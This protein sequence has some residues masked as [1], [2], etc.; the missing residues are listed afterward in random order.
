MKNLFFLLALIAALPASAQRDVV[1]LR[2]RSNVPLYDC[3]IFSDRRDREACVDLRRGRTISYESGGYAVDC[4][5]YRGRPQRTCLRLAENITFNDYAFDCYS[6]PYVQRRRCENTKEGYARGLLTVRQPQAPIEATTTVITTSSGSEVPSTCGPGSYD[7]AYNNWL[8]R[9]EEQ[10]RRGRDRAI[11]GGVIAVG[12]IILGQSDNRTTRGIGNAMTI[13]GSYMVAHGLV[14]M[15]DAANFYPHLDAV[16]GGFYLRETR[17][18]I[19]EER[20]CTS[21]RYTEH[22]WNSSRSYYEVNCESRR[23]VTYESFAP[24]ETS[25]SVVMY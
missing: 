13:G 17:R 20:Q 19:V 24:F 12:G 5:S 4:R 23:Y 6:N 7:R 25:T 18:V 21:T 3:S 9:R 14:E 1:D 16:C 10:R 2:D 15:D 11:L 8:I 22:G